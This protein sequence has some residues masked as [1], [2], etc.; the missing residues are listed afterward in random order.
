VID[1]VDAS[2]KSTF[3]DWLAE[4]LRS[5]GRSAQVIHVDDFVHVSSV[6][7]RRGRNSPEG[8]FH[9][10]YA[11]ASLTRYVV[12]PLSASGDGWFVPALSIVGLLSLPRC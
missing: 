10:S 5:F 11:Y 3:A 1:G 4:A 7:H 9:D 6:R 12:Q 2:G 8:Y